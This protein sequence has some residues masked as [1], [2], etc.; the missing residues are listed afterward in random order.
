MASKR[1]RSGS[2]DDE[3]GM[4]A[5]MAM[6]HNMNMLAAVGQGLLDSIDAKDSV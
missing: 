2:I 1:H 4:A 5:G 6:I 3:V